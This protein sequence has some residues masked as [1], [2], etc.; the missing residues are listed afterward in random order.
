MSTIVLPKETTQALRELTGEVQPDAALT[1]ALRDAFAY[2]LEQIQEQLH[3]F[4][5][6]YGMPFADYKTRWESGDQEED[7]S[8]EAER[9]YLEWEALITRK[10]R[11]ENTYHQ[12]A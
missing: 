6:K 9:D 3:A 7:Y 8:W 2:R 11:L 4:E 5:E 10:R 1:L 12:F